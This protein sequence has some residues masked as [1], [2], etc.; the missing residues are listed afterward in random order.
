MSEIRYRVCNY[1]GMVI[2]NFY[3]NVQLAKYDNSTPDANAE[4]EITSLDLCEVCKFKIEKQINKTT[5][6]T[7]QRRRK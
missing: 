7:A 5:K 6:I 1:C 4:P 3:W 2:N